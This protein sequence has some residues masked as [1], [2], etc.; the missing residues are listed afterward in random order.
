MIIFK[1]KPAPP[2]KNCGHKGTVTYAIY[3]NKEDLWGNKFPDPN[4]CYITVSAT[5]N[6]NGDL[7][8][9]YLNKVFSPRLELLMVNFKNQ[10]GLSLMLLEATL[11][12]K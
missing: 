12:R 7:T 2:G 8:I 9:D 1:A 5:A 3:W 10:L 4:D 11:I 6:S